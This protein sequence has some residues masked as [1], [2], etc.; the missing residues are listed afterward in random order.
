MRTCIRIGTRE[1]FGFLCQICHCVIALSQLDA[2]IIKKES[3]SKY[4]RIFLINTSNL[5][6]YMP[7]L[8]TADDGSFPY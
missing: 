6:S 4:L 5:F 1:L 3:K 8:W 2:K 7:G